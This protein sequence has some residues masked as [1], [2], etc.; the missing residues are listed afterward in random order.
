MDTSLTDSHL[1]AAPPLT[2]H[3]RTRG[4]RRWFP[5]LSIFK[6][7]TKR[8]GITLCFA[9]M[10]GPV[11]DRLKTYGL[12]D[13]IGAERFFPTIGQAVDRYVDLN[14]VDWTDWEDSKPQ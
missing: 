1:P 3:E 10:K 4:V 14:Q 12:F 11:K 5:V 13:T 9:Q 7:Q 2:R 8:S 6:K